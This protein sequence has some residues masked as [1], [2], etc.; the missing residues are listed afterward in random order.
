MKRPVKHKPKAKPKGYD[1][2]GLCNRL[3]AESAAA[4]FELIGQLG[5]SGYIT[6]NDILTAIGNRVHLDIHTSMGAENLFVAKCRKQGGSGYE[7]RLQFPL[8]S[9]S[10]SH[11]LIVA[12]TI[13][14]VQLCKR[15]GAFQ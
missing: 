3:Q 12:A 1:F 9:I 2:D 8:Y 4:R 11:S 5:L 14:Y 7:A 13:A 10:S 15:F 6:D